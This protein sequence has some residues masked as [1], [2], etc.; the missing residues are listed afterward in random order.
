MSPSPFVSHVAPALRIILLVLYA[1]V[2]E[3]TSRSKLDVTSLFESLI[4][5]RE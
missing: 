3:F 5:V 1:S 4:F 2:D